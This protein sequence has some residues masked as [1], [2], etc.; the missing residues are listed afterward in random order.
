MPQYYCKTC[1]RT[2]EANQFYMSRRIDKYPP[3]GH[4]HECKKCLTR[5]VNNDDPSTY[6]WILQEA[7]VPYIEFEWQRLLDRYGKDRTKLTGTTILG[8][9]LGKMRMQQYKDYHWEDSQRIKE[10]ANEAAVQSM[11]SWGYSP[12]EIEEVISQEKEVPAVVERPPEPESE[13]EP[14]QEP[15]ESAPIDLIAPEYFDDDLTE[16][17]KKYLSIKWGRVYKPYEWVQLE[18][19]YADMI[20]AFDI[21][22][23]AHIDYL[24]L[25][26]KTSLKCHQL[27]DLGDKPI[28]YVAFKL[29]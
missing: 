23:P 27:L 25:I 15:A 11:S 2:M 21:Q 24:K 9:Y 16:E 4:F 18:Q 3:D 5:H 7:D 14:A 22:T 12:E 29:S 13:P 17:D 8:R 10:K 20:S 28:K 6:L 26:C 1:G 19:Y